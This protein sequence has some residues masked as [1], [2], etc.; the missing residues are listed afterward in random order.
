[1]IGYTDLIG[2]DGV[3]SAVRGAMHEQADGFAASVCDLPGRYK[4]FVQPCPPGLDPLAV[5]AMGAKGYSLFSI[6]KRG[7]ELCTLLA[8][9]D[10]EPFAG[11]ADHEIAA[12]IATDVPKYGAP[13]LAA[14]AQLR[15]QQPS[16]ATTV[17]CSRYHDPRGRALLLGDAAHSTGGT[18]GQGANSALLD[19]LALDAL[20]RRGAPAGESVV[21][22]VGE[23]F[24]CLLYTSP[25]PRD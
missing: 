12:A 25:S 18:L 24:S 16:K 2:A 22:A 6:P 23:A 13:T 8:W 21:E 1:M 4:V 5:H 10:D 7:N 11:R 14:L 20:L 17:R 15:A 3:N 19:V 9:R